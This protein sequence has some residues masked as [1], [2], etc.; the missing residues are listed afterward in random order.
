MTLLDELHAKWTRDSERR[1]KDKRN[2]RDRARR[3]LKRWLASVEDRAWRT[4]KV[5]PCPECRSRQLC[6]PECIVAPWNLEP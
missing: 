4:T 1:R 6:E 3:R 2:A 5:R